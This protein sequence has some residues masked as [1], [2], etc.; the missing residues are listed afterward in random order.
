MF[1]V[2]QLL[3]VFLLG[4]IAGCSSMPEE[5][6]LG[7]KVYSERNA[8]LVVGAMVGSGPYGTWLEFREINTDKRF[9]WAVKDYYSAWLPA[10]E[11]EVSSL[12]SRRGVMGP[13]SGSLRFS[14]KQG[15]VNYLGELVYGCAAESRPAALYGVM[16]CGFLAL[17]SCSVP[18]PSVGV[19]MVDRQEQALRIFLKAHPEYADLPV[20]SSTMG[21]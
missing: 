19:C 14:V 11:Y 7:S 10:G 17:G 3:V 6:S 16:N 8:G 4:I 15:E 9:G 5:M 1:G 18:S 13:Y 21:R 12:G 20:R 2:R